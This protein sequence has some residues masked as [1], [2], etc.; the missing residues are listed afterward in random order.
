MTHDDDSCD[1]S[2]DPANLAMWW[3]LASASTAY[4]YEITKRGGGL[5]CEA[6]RAPTA[7]DD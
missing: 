3:P 7:F 1:D 5:A 6:S 4:I 2:D